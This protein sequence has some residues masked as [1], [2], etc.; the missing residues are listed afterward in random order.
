M[1]AGEPSS[2]RPR[3]LA[4][5]EP[6][7]QNATPLQLCSERH[8]AWQSGTVASAPLSVNR[9]CLLSKSVSNL[10]FDAGMK[11]IEKLTV[12]GGVVGGEVRR[13]VGGSVGGWRIGGVVAGGKVGGVE[14]G[15][16]VSGA[17]GGV[18]G[19]VV[20]GGAVGG[21]VVGGGAVGGL[22]V[23]GVDGGVVGETTTVQS[24][25]IA[26]LWICLAPRLC[27][28]QHRLQATVKYLHASM[29]KHD[30]AQISTFL[31][32]VMPFGRK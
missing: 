4:L 26:R 30:S 6:D 21:V 15:G 5:S 14:V 22:V 16:T 32:S 23:G 2:L 8:A 29:F 7:S 28:R 20:V 19:G 27:F 17:V 3:H 25:A 13:S 11:T 12:G 18:D 31:S 10:R 24:P 1:P 9:A